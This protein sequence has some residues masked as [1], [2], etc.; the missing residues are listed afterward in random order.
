M[1]H[2]RLLVHCVWATNNREAILTDEKRI[3]LVN[4]IKENSLKKDIFI[5]TINGHY[6]HIHCLISLGASQS[7]DKVM[8]LIK[9]EASYWANNENLFTKKLIWAEDYFAGSV[10]ES[11]IDRVREYIKNQQEHHKKI[12]FQQEYDTFIKAHGFKLG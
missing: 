10:S 1:S 6:D 2:V 7:I 8:Q 4:H 9:G 11:S 3:V 5:D 12:T